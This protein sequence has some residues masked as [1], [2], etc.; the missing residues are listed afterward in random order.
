MNTQRHQNS[1]YIFSPHPDDETLSC[2]GTIIKRL[3]EGYNVKIIVMTDGSKSHSAN[4]NIYSNP[5]PKELAEIRKQETKDAASI[6]GVIPENI[7]FLEAEDGGLF[8]VKEIMID[9]VTALL[10]NEIVNI[11]EIFL[12]HKKDYH[13]DHI[14]TNSIVLEAIERLKLKALL[15]YYKI[16]PSI[17]QENNCDLGTKVEINI[18]DFLPIKIR[19]INQ[20]KSQIQIS[21]TKQDRP[22]ISLTLLSRFCTSPVET[23]WHS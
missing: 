9:I 21:S 7:V 19:A 2:G 4:F 11:S 3:S 14:A 22:V 13:D 20:Y 6:L 23:F 17:T 18:S 10:E 16:Y 12:P 15:Y 1:I 8:N 5:T